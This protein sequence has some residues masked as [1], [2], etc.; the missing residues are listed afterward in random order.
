MQYDD[1]AGERSIL[2]FHVHVFVETRLRWNDEDDSYGSS[3]GGEKKGKSKGK[4][5]EGMSKG[6]DNGRRC[7][8]RNKSRDDERG[9]LPLFV[10]RDG[11]EYF[12]PHMMVY[13]HT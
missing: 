11:Y 4:S 8:R 12:P 3:Y 6:Q 5:E 10:P 9:L 2:L 7:E 1:N 13:Q